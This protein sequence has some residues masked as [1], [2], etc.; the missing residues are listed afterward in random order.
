MQTAAQKK[1]AANFKKAVAIRKKTGC[2]LKDAFAEVYGNKKSAPKKKVGAFA[3]SEAIERMD[4]LTKSSD[5]IKFSTG[6]NNIIDDLLDEG[7]ELPEI[8]EYIKLRLNIIYN[9]IK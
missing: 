2:S 9:N 4:G 3:S 7:F 1:V 6:L 8:K 5:L